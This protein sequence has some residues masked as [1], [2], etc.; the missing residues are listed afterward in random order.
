MASSKSS[1]SGRS[2]QSTGAL[3]P[4]PAPVV[5]EL[6]AVVP[7]A[8]APPLPLVDVLLPA[9]LLASEVG[10]LLA[11]SPPQAAARRPRKRQGAH[12]HRKEKDIVVEMKRKV[13]SMTSA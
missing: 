1:Q 9:P 7:D 6:I 12:A 8:P 2:L 4:A 13:V 3:P 10:G 11:L 5:L